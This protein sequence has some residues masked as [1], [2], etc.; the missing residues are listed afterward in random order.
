M[1]GVMEKVFNSD[2]EMAPFHPDL[3]LELIEVCSNMFTGH[4]GHK[5][6]K[7]RN[8]EIHTSAAFWRWQFWG[9]LRI[10]G[11]IESLYCSGS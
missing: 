2:M 11:Q 3:L 5:A 4:K 9:S 8:P 1:K 6:I 7:L 10:A